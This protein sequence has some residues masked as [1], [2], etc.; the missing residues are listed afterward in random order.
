[1]NKFA[2]I[3]FFTTLFCKTISAQQTFIPDD[4]FEQVLIDLGVDD[5]LDN[6]VLTTI[7]YPLAGIDR[8][9]YCIRSKFLRSALQ[10]QQQGLCVWRY[11]THG[12][13]G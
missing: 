6:Y 7:I 2:L 13:W 11:C 9:N 8:S 4:N 10:Q 12:L 3:I 1:M 5:T